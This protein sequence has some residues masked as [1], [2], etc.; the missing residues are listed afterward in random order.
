MGQEV[1][2]HLLS[3]EGGQEGLLVSPKA[4]DPDVASGFQLEWTYLQGVS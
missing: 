3:R 4:P 2:I 1:Q